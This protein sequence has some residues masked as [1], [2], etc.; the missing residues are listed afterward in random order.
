M[1]SMRFHPRNAKNSKK[2][3]VKRSRVL[4]MTTMI[5]MKV[6]VVVVVVDL[7]AATDRVDNPKV[8]RVTTM[9]TCLKVDL[10]SEAT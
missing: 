1:S 10:I 9:T 6:V 2:N 5:A 8:V 7:L 4:M 3:L